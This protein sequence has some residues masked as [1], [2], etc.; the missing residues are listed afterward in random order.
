M[1][2]SSSMEEPKVTKPTE[3]KCDF[4]W[5]EHERRYPKN[6]QHCIERKCI[7]PA[8]GLMLKVGQSINDIPLEE[9][10]RY[11]WI[12]PDDM[13]DHPMY[14]EKD[15]GARMIRECKEKECCEEN[16]KRKKQKDKEDKIDQQERT[17]Q[18]LV[19]HVARLTEAVNKLT[20]GK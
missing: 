11:M 2:C 20:K 9:R 4:D 14:K 19:D 18:T 17:I 7:R 3:V 12:V 13:K 15:W 1:W 5:V 10:H 8:D 16:E 6:K